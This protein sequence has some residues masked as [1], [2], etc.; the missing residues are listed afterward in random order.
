MERGN[1]A[2]AALRTL[3]EKIKTRM[4]DFMMAA[5]TMIEGMWR[6]ALPPSGALSVPHSAILKGSC[7]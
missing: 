5:R 4:R 7:I 6:A 1:E 3:E 2:I